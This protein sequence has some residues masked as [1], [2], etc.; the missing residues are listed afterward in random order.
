M[1]S[2]TV[3]LFLVVWLAAVSFLLAKKRKQRAM[4]GTSRR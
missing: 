3:F 1:N 4:A 2:I